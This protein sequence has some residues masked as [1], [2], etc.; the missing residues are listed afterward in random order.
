MKYIVEGVLEFE[1]KTKNLSAGGLLGT[2]KFDSTLKIGAIIDIRF[3]IPDHPKT[4]RLP[5][6]IVRIETGPH[7]KKQNIAVKFI[8]SKEAQQNQIIKFLFQYQRELK[9]KRAL[10]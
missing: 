5:A 7:Q 6:Q 1:G 9:A 4:L 2:I 8:K 10:I 3:S